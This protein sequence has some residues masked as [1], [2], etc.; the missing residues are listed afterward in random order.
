MIAFEICYLCVL[1]LSIDP[2][3]SIL[4]FYPIQLNSVTSVRFAT[5]CS[6]NIKDAASTLRTPS[7][8]ADKW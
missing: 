6:N 7:H 3:I 4:T 5:I 2:S 8:F 1:Y